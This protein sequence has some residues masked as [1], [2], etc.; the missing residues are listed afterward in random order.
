MIVHSFSLEHHDE[1]VWY[2]IFIE[3]L[4]LDEK[5]LYLVGLSKSGEG[6]PT[7]EELRKIALNAE[8]ISPFEHT[9]SIQALCTLIEDS[10]HA[11]TL[12]VPFL[13]SEKLIEIKTPVSAF[14]EG[15]YDATRGLHYNANPYVKGTNEFNEWDE[16]WESGLEGITRDLKR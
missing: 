11:A 15:Q 7:K 3:P 2:N 13:I 12:E 16:G 1:D 10:L 9:V 4:D 8:T 5:L 6:I 14:E